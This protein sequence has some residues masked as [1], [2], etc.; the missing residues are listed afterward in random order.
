VSSEEH[1]V[2]GDRE[3]SP[4]TT[5]AVYSSEDSALW[6]DTSTED[7]D[8]DPDRDNP[9]RE[10]DISVFKITGN[11]AMELNMVRLDMDPLAS[12]SPPP[13]GELQ[14]RCKSINPSQETVHIATS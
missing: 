1:S 13:I 4:A 10:T 5:A 12:L 8:E 9:S 7:G 3:I 6:E 14:L 11:E 2:G